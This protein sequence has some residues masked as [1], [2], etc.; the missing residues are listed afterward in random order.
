M[1]VSSKAAVAAYVSAFLRALD[2]ASPAGR[3]LTGWLRYNSSLLGLDFEAAIRPAK[4]AG[5]RPRAPSADRPLS[6]RAW[7]KLGK[8]LDA[9]ATREA[10][11]PDPIAENFAA[12]VDAI[13]LSVEQAAVLRLVF[14]AARDSTFDRLCDALVECRVADNYGLI[15]L[16][17]GTDS[18]AV[19]RAANSANLAGLMKIY[20]GAGE[21]FSAYIPY[22]VINALLPPN[23]GLAAI[24]RSLIGAPMP[25]ELTLADF[26]HIGS[27]CDFLLRLLRNALDRRRPGINVLLVGVPGTGKTEL[28][29]TLA[30]ELRCALFAIG[31][32]DDSGAEPDRGERLDALKLAAPLAARRGNAILLFDEMQDLLADESPNGNAQKAGSK[33]YFNRMLEQ[34]P[35]P[36]LWTS[37]SI[38]ECDPAFLRRM[39][40]ILE[41]QA[42]PIAARASMLENGAR[43]CGLRIDPGQAKQLARR[44]PVAPAILKGAVQAVAIAGGNAEE[45][46][47]VAGP[48]SRF[49]AGR[50]AVAPAKSVPFLPELANADI[51]LSMIERA[52]TA[53]AAS[54]LS[55]FFY[56]PPG[57]GK[58][59]FARHLAETMALE[60]MLR[61]GSDLL[62]KWIG[63][64]EKQ[65]ARAFA[66]A[67][68]DRRF[69]IIDE[70]EPFLWNRSAESRSWEVSMV[71]ELL[72]QM[73]S[74][75][76]PF[77]CTTNLPEA[78]DSAA[79]RRFS[80]KV[81]F[82]Y[83]TPD[84]TAKAY[85]HFFTRE[86]PPSL[87]HLT[88]LTP[89]DFAS[90]AKRCRL[91]NLPMDRD[92]PLLTMLEGEV[93][94]KRLPTRKIGF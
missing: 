6:G 34:N 80:L 5:R 58:S 7:A 70:A 47:L 68:N 62:S 24:E 56:G 69:L 63:D 87:R 77:A 43:Q 55:L 28:C 39:T 94:G 90:V 71:D 72:I 75:T 57:T 15:A 50:R 18:G 22:R 59:A 2:P 53:S 66:E 64:T 19:V 88:A 81:K 86:A 93:A 82:D 12:F 27:E 8:T 10:S 31:E 21:R 42:M 49:V 16:G 79:L 89:S 17:L 3:R 46:D 1:V 60:P 44:Y 83:L 41:M 35:V 65:L 61:R 11:A 48:M 4:R 25:A 14:E 32:A 76:L 9:I 84:Q 36:V 45:I 74:H 54:E 91:L 92:A 33:V 37:N 78:V 73:E 52:A 38:R 29:K 26:D 13:G 67:R 40:Y 51:D 30:A 85:A 23:H 20:G